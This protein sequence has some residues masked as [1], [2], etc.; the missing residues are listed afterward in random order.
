LLQV[1]NLLP[2]TAKLIISGFKLALAR[3]GY[4]PVG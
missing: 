3:K 1:F 2:E 4:L